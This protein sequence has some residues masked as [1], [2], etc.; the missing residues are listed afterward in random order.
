VFGN[1]M[2]SPLRFPW[3]GFTVVLRI[4]GIIPWVVRV[5]C[6]YEFRYELWSVWPEVVEENGSK[7][8][9]GLHDRVNIQVE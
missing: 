1:Y 6:I 8:N 3:V 5:A 7:E 9:K 4:R 2:I